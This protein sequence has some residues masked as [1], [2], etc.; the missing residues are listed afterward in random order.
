MLYQILWPK[1]AM[2]RALVVETSAVGKVSGFLF[3]PPDIQVPL[4]PKVMSQPLFGTD[5]TVEDVA[6]AY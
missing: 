2:G 6:E 1:E 4:T 3:E 5:V